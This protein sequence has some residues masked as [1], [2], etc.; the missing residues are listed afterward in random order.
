[1]DGSQGNLD[2]NTDTCP[3][4]TPSGAGDLYWFFAFQAGSGSDGVTPGYTY[5]SDSGGNEGCYNPACTAGSQ[6]PVL[7]DVAARLGMA[8]LIQ[9]IVEGT[10]VNAGNAEATGTAPQAAGPV[11]ISGPNYA[12]SAADLGGG[13]GSWANAGNADNAPDSTWATWTAP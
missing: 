2:A 12:G 8:V 7:G 11:L 13:S 6:A 4:L 5:Y 10:S 3:S 1:M 9:E